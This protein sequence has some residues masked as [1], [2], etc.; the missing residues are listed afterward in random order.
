[1]RVLLSGYDSRGGVEPLVGLAAVLRK[2]GAE[3]RVCA[4]PDE[5][6]AARSAEVGV[7]FTPVGFSVRALMTGTVA[8]SPADV[9]RRGE[10][11]IAEQLDLVAGEAEGCDVVLGTGLLPS[12]AGAASV[13]ELLGV[14]YVYASYQSISLPSPH[15]RPMERPLHPLPADLTD[16]RA[17]WEFDDRAANALFRAGLNTHRAAHGLP[18]VE[19]VRDLGFTGRPWLASD[20]ILDPWPE[21]ADRAVVQ[22]GAWIVPDERRLPEGLEAFLDAGDPP[23]YVGFGSSAMRSSQ[24]LAQV[25][26]AAV[27]AQGR[28]AVLARGWADLAAVDGAED[29]FVVGEAN[30]QALFRRVAAAVHHGGAGTTTTAAFAGAPQ[31]LVPQLGD[32]PHFAARVAALGIGAHH[33]GPV[34][35]FESLSAALKIALAPETAERAAEVAAE[36]RADGAATAARMLLDG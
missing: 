5:E 35:T 3:V 22:T 34:P 23:V 2:A 32:Q 17:L 33:D 7:R 8:P 30:H 16:D 36:V 9:P 4:P 1:M 27:R 25:V 28:R 24:G 20:P 14:R 15:H 10:A 13:A 11:L 6:F 29:C 26:V 21:S 31:V 19:S 18:P 12:V